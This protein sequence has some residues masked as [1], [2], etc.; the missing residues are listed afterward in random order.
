MT[1]DQ[2]IVEA[3]EKILVKCRRSWAASLADVETLVGYTIELGLGVA[4][5]EDEARQAHQLI[6]KLMVEAYGRA[7]RPVPGETL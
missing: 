7:P 1:G 4:A 2:E 5:A 6:E 3:A